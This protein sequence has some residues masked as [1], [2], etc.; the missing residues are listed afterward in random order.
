MD[1]IENYELWNDI[2]YSIQGTTDSIASVVEDYAERL[3][4]ESIVD[5]QDYLPF[6]RYLDSIIF[7][8]DCCSWWCEVSEA[9]EHEDYGQ[10][11][12]NDCYSD[13]EG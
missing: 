11:I 1:N 5:L 13:I 7:L 4:D 9:N 8:C 10:D 3:Q 2:I 6:L 12:C